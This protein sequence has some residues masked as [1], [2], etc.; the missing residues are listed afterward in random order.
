MKKAILLAAVIGFAAALTA[1]AAGAKE[2][3]DTLCAKCHGMD[4]KGHTNIG[5]ILG[6]KD[7]S[8][9]KVQA[10]LTDDAAFK[11]VKEGLKNSDGK[12][13]MKAYSDLS[14]DDIKALVAY[15]RTFK[16]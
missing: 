5:R 6:V 1:S 2:N 3:W 12:I 16:Q 13:Q 8:D 14:D 15:L 10:A 11:A 7:Y 9:A 4:G